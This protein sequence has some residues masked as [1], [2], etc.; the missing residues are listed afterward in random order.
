VRVQ[1]SM[2][3][4]V[5]TS[6]SGGVLCCVHVNFAAFGSQLPLGTHAAADDSG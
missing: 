5:P 3:A 4:V 2:T 1:V 6:T